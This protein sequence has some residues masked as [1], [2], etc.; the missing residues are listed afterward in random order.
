[1]PFSTCMHSTSVKIGLALIGMGGA[2]LALLNIR[3]DQPLQARIVAI[4]SSG[5]VKRVTVE[6]QRRDLTARFEDSPAVCTR[7]AGRWQEPQ[8]FPEPQGRCLLDRTNHE[9]IVFT[10]PAET[11]ACRFY[12]GYRSGQNLYCRAYFFLFNH[13]IAQRFQ[14]VT[15]L[16]LKPIPRQARLRHAEFDLMIPVNL[17][18][19]GALAVWL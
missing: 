15:R 8:L 14:N 17:S 2:A 1:M 5:A 4:Q 11:D 3:H 16:A 10:V 13:G 9:E 19:G 6:F 7:V 12:L 18:P